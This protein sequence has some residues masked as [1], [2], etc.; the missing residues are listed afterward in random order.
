MAFS[1]LAA[2]KVEYSESTVS[3]QA[4]VKKRSN[5]KIFAEIFMFIPL[6]RD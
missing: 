6:A 2:S 3:E 5:I 1:F 4:D